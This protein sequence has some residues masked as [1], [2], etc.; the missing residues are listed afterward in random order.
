MKKLV[1]K[2]NSGGKSKSG[3]TGKT[4]RGKTVSKRSSRDSD[5]SKTF[6]SGRATGSSKS[7]SGFGVRSGKSGGNFKRKS[8]GG[9][10]KRDFEKR[11]DDVFVEK[12]R[13]GKSDGKFRD[14][15]PGVRREQGKFRNEQEK[16]A[17]P[18]GRFNDKFAD[19][20]QF[21]EELAAN[22]IYGRN[23]VAE[24][25][26]AEPDKI[27]KIYLQFGA[28]GEQLARIEH[29]ARKA[30]VPVS[31]QDKFK[32]RDLESSAIP[33]GASSQ[34]VIALKS[35]A[36]YLT[37]QELIE[38]AYEE[39]EAPIIVILDEIEDPRNFGAIA[40][41]AECAGAAGIIVT[42]RNSAPVTPAAVKTSAGA[43]NYLPVAR[44]SS[45]IKALEKLKD[46]NFNIVGTVV[47][48]SKAY[49][50]INYSS[51]V[52]VIIGSEDKGIRPS[53]LKYCNE[54]VAI[55]LAGKIESLNASVSAGILLFEILK[56]RNM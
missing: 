30:K 8:S 53:T 40:R 20:S 17:K 46:E 3:P 44:V 26:T 49:Y 42:E 43:L 10:F 18:H 28:H 55:P 48:A 50:D 52:A 23:A 34:G 37:I 4:G 39:S 36:E 45:L 15:K 14:R 7:R 32:F 51:P 16:S 11:D 41:S 13:T 6:S 2:F 25:L 9:E 35:A 29:L 21:D 24:A 54:K 27:E 5:D 31:V 12:P 33:S 56:Q 19:E 22:Y 1:S 38:R 47:G